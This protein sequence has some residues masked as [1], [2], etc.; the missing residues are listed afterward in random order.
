MAKLHVPGVQR[1]NLISPAGDI[2]VDGSTAVGL[3]TKTLT[4]AGRAR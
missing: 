3:G 4:F 1:V 2:V